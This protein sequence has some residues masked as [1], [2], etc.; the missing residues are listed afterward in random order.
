MSNPFTHKTK[1]LLVALSTVFT[2]PFLL[3]CDS[4]DTISACIASYE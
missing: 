3:C 2:E 1:I 4:V